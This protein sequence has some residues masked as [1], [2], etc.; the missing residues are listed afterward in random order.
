MQPGKYRLQ[1][2][3]TANTFRLVTG[4]KRFALLALS[5]HGP[6]ML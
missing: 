6:L 1:H 5:S 3:M 2:I 4:M